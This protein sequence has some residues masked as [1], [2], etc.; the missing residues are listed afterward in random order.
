MN[1]N[2]N[3]ENL[4][5]LK[6]EL[7][8]LQKGA[9]EFEKLKA[10]YARH[11][12]AVHKLAGRADLILNVAT[13]GFFILDENGILADVNQALCQLLGYEKDELIGMDIRR[14]EAIETS[15]ETSKHI[16]KIMQEGSDRF[17]T[18]NRRKDGS[19]VDVEVSINYLQAAED[20]CFYGLARDLSGHKKMEEDIRESEQ[21]Y[22]KLVEIFPH[23]IIIFQDD[24]VVFANEATAQM[25]GFEN[26]QRLIGMDSLE[27]VPDRLKAALKQ[28]V[29]DNVIGKPGAH[30]CNQTSLKRTDGKE[31]PVDVYAAA[32]TYLGRPAIQA[33]VINTYERKEAENALQKSEEAFRHLVENVN[34]V[35][36]TIDHNEV[37]T[38]ASPAVEHILGYNPAEMIGQKIESFIYAEDMAGVRQAF[39]DVLNGNLKPDE[40]RVVTKTGKIKWV[41]TSSRPFYEGD[42]IVGIQ[43]VLVDITE[44]KMAEEAL[45]ESEAKY[46]TIVENMQDVFYRADLEGNII[47][48]SPSGLRLLGYDS[49]DQLSNLNLA[50]DFYYDINDRDKVLQAMEASGFVSDYEVKLK[51][52]DG[53]FIYAAATSHFYYGPNGERLGVEG[54]CR[55]ITERKLAEEALRKSEEFSRAA[56]E[57]S[58]L[59]VSVRS[60]SGKL[61]SCNKAWRVI[62]EK[63]DEEIDQSMLRERHE[64]R[65]DE[66]DEYLKEWQPQIK[67]I[68]EK[69]GYLHLP[70]SRLVHPRADGYY[71]VSKHFYAIKDAIGQV[72]RVVILTEDITEG[73][74]AEEAL[75]NSQ[76]RLQAITDVLPDLL[77]V[78]DEQGRYV[79]ILS[80]TDNLLYAPRV[81]L[82]G[83]LMQ[84]ILPNEAADQY[85][86]I[87]RKTI[88]TGQPQ[89]FEYKL[90]ISGKEMWFDGKTTILKTKID[91]E[92]CVVW[93]ARD[94][95]D[96][97]QAGE[98]LR[99]SEIRFH[100][101]FQNSLNCYDLCEI[102]LDENGKPVD[103]KYLE[104]NQAFE[105]LIGA[106]ADQIV[107]KC[108]STIFPQIHN[109]EFIEKMG[110]VALTGEP[111]QFEH[112]SQALCKY[113]EI[114][115]FCPRK[116]QFASTFFDVTDRK[117]ADKAIR[118]NEERYRAIWQNSPVGIC[119]NDRDGIYHY[120]NPTYCK[121]YGYTE[122]ELIG[123]N[124]YDRILPSNHPGQ[125]I[126]NFYR[127]FDNPERI[128]FGETTEFIKKNGQPVFIQYSSDFV[129]A[130]G[131]PKFMVSFNVD[132]T[133]K[134]RAEMALAENEENYRLV[135]ENAGEVIATID[136]EGK[137]LLMN[138]AA[139]N[140]LGGKSEDFI[141]KTLWELFPKEY[142]DRMIQS[143]RQ[144]I[145]AGTAITRDTA[146]QIK[147]ELKFYRTNIQA[148]VDSD[149]KITRALIMATDFTEQKKIELR[150]GVRLSLLQNLRKAN[151][152]D[153]CLTYGCKAIVDAQ[154]FRRAVL[155]LHN[156]DR[157]II[158]LGQVGLDEEVVRQAR[159]QQ[160]PDI[161]LANKIIQKKYQISNSYFIPI[162]DGLFIEKAQ[163]HIP[164]EHYFGEDEGLWKVGDELFVPIIGRD[165]KKKE[166]WLS[167]DTPYN[168][169][170]P[171]LDIILYLEEV[172]D[173][174]SKQVHQIQS[175]ENLLSERRAL[176]DKN[177]ALREV[178]T[179]IEDQKAEI[180]EKIGAN[181]AQIL[182]PALNKLIKK[183]GTV[184]QTYYKQ[185]KNGLPELVTASGILIQLY[186]KLSPREREICNMIKNGASSKEIAAELNIA[187]AT[188]QKHRELIREKFGIVN[189]D[190]NLQN[191]LK[192]T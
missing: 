39:V 91:G 109:F 152:I 5:N 12:D 119:L 73:K 6:A 156:N 132:I 116:G 72:D 47:M 1:L 93:A 11:T 154:L 172:L 42:A 7:E 123:Q 135:I 128:M 88:S 16:Q 167:V 100:E 61:I 10:D 142:A 182:M 184:N 69:G 13:D 162:E 98:A 174:V 9:E 28:F 80:S 101:L 41:R 66:E 14:I 85:L 55:N 139:A 120:V 129:W 148:I 125:E 8:R 58:P 49:F 134:K 45:K 43:G 81:D 64:L 150:E 124:L 121:I 31:F 15:E 191:F 4:D 105:E 34:D 22:R 38:Y 176:E 96:K 52:R 136:Y 79:E 138:R 65:F 144:A 137:Y 59:G 171:T 75:H 54:V 48:A 86:S 111:L 17:K 157:D 95:T 188:V 110:R 25:L 71:W 160:A 99:Q 161:E 163:R 62:F 186:A 84:E 56:I 187:L 180:K 179:T 155:T 185:L 70:E 192:S 37:I 3:S 102:I 127:H 146:V 67:E 130:D 32:M 131:K 90:D 82:K 151:S 103:F 107:G 166:G 112:Y 97:K 18:K 30:F 20:R 74:R 177:I 165:N 23:A 149:G 83:H 145:S 169:R 178:F 53:S 51:R 118:E 44:R 108:S 21:K 46:R 19:L 33:I 106:K 122:E 126:R 60:R 68:Y 50:R 26:A 175:F 94:I 24:K 153:E 92:N 117:T 141:G 147:G 143:I 104:V 170:R 63:S 113:F 89:H 36:F 133:E 29:M 76:E 2:G 164:Q 140:A 57:H 114:A 115:A 158:N 190:I 78:L 77:L 87:V 189:K 27:P 35:L 40:Y 173:I 183:D 181:V 159:N 168:G